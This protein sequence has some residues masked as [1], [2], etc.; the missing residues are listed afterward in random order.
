MPGPIPSPS[1]GGGGWQV[2]FDIDFSAL[3]NQTISADGPVTLGGVSFNKINSANEIAHLAVVNGV[4]LRFTPVSSPCDWFA[5]RKSLPALSANLATVIPNYT[6]TTP[7]RAWVRI[8]NQNF[9]AN[10]DNLMMGFETGATGGPTV[11]QTFV[12][13]EIGWDSNSGSTPGASF[14][15]AQNGG[16]IG[17]T[18]SG[19]S[20]YNTHNLLYVEMPGGVANSL[21]C[22]MSGVS[23]GAT[24]PAS[25]A[26]HQIGQSCGTN[27]HTQLVA[28]TD[29]NMTFGIKRA[30]SGTSLVVD[31]DRVRLEYK[32]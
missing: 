7:V 24:F 20:P 29:W 14:L 27:F 18:G 12:A 11:A 9:A 28:P 19:T 32:P 26:L 4:G 5:D 23:S 31:I 2:A 13:G 15:V 30:G 17:N 10:F 1:A 22:V 21:G 16:N 6:L 8:K 25:S 3:S